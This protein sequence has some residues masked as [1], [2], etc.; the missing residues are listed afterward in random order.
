MR[1]PFL[2]GLTPT[3]L[4]IITLPIVACGVAPELAPEHSPTNP[5]DQSIELR[6]F[7]GPPDVLLDVACTP[8][9]FEVCFDAIDNNCNGLIDEGCGIRSGLVQFAIAWTDAAADVDLDVVDTSGSSTRSKTVTTDGFEKDRN[10][11]GP[12][13]QCQ[14]QNMENVFLRTMTVPRGTLRVIVR[15]VRLGNDVPPMQVRMGARVGQRSYSSIILLE[16]VGS[17]R[18]MTFEL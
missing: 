8:S 2:L 4:L 13:D 16:E 7:A 17:A 5:K 10:C 9:A 15:W 14:G 3:T 1:Y 6:G 18:V 11:P 12:S